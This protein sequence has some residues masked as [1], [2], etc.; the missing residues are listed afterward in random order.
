MAYHSQLFGE[1]LQAYSPVYHSVISHLGSYV[2]SVT[3]NIGPNATRQAQYILQSNLTKQAFIES[4]DDDFMLAAVITV[5]SAIPVFFLKGSKRKLKQKENYLEASK[6]VV[7]SQ[8][9]NH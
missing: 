4:I 7:E 2:T 3:G 9:S 6:Q 5:I 8:S 1:S